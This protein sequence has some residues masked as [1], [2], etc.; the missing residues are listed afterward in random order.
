MSDQVETN[1]YYGNNLPPKVSDP[2]ELV[3]YK[4]DAFAHEDEFRIA[5]FYPSDK[6]G[7]LAKEGKT[8]PFYKENESSH[9]TL[10]YPDADFLK[11][12]IGNVY[13]PRA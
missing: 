9:L 12:F 1:S 3:F 6:P 13:E 2:E 10:S 11:Q 5:L 4:P 8:I 7:F